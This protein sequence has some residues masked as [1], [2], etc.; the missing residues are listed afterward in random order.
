MVGGAFKVTG[1]LVG[2]LLT[3]VALLEL[4][5][6]GE[7]TWTPT[8]S[9]PRLGGKTIHLIVQVLVGVDKKAV[10]LLRWKRQD[11]VCVCARVSLSLSLYL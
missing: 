6:P 1:S 4:A 7:P 8:A 10:E 2:E 3:F 5:S 11:G 9:V